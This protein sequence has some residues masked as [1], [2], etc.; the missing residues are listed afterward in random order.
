MK[1]LTL[2]VMYALIF[3]PGCRDRQESTTSNV[4]TS[5]L[6]KQGIELAL[7]K[8]VQAMSEFQSDLNPIY[9]LVNK[10]N[11][12][13]HIA[14]KSHSEAEG[15]MDTHNIFV[16]FEQESH[17]YLSMNTDSVSKGKKISLTHYEIKP[18]TAPR[19]LDGVVFNTDPQTAESATQLSN[20][21]LVKMKA[22]LAKWGKSYVSNFSSYFN[23]RPMF[24]TF[25]LLCGVIVAVALHI[26]ATMSWAYSQTRY[27]R[28]AATAVMY[29]TVVLAVLLFVTAIGVAFVNVFPHIKSS[30]ERLRKYFFESRSAAPAN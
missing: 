10:Q 22:F 13:R 8:D 4:K 6:D 29:T 25:V 11:P 27:G 2:V 19:K 12:K 5:Q 24:Y 26:F 15:K 28:V 23:E 14:L 17:H 20:A 30:P 16:K 1:H 3:A 21:N 7:Q 18:N 9:L